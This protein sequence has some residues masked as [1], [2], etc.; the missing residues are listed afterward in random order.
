MLSIS[1]NLKCLSFGC[2][3]IKLKILLEYEDFC[4]S[5]CYIYWDDNDLGS[6]MVY[7]AL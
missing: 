7:L 1:P 3:F 5:K 6:G 2:L 4:P